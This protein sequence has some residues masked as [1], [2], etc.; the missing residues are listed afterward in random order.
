M[1]T[2]PLDSLAKPGWLDEAVSALASVGLLECVDGR[3]AAPL[4]NDDLAVALARGPSPIGCRGTWSLPAV[5]PDDRAGALFSRGCSAETMGAMDLR[6][7]ARN[8]GVASCARPTGG[9]KPA[10]FA[11]RCESIVPGGL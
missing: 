2:M 10:A 7:L 4:G 11:A 1:A 6:R 5:F 3:G 8:L 9:R